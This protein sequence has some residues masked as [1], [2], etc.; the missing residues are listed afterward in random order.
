[1]KR[2]K[3]C[4]F[5]AAIFLGSNVASAKIG[6]NQTDY[7][8]RHEVAVSYG[9]FSNSSVI[10]TFDDILT[11]MVTGG[12]GYFDN[13]KF[14]GPISAEYFYRVN[15]WL[16]VGGIG[17]YATQGKDIMSEFSKTTPKEGT[18]RLNYYTLMPALKAD[19]LR[20]PHFGMYSKLGLGAT[21]FTDSHSYNDGTKNSDSAVGFTWQA[22]LLGLEAG[23][24]S[25][26]G[27]LEFS[28]IGEQGSIVI[29]LRHKF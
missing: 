1:M 13:E 23:S 14:I 22:S 19:W 24:N 9:F 15:N 20:R 25:L 26:R 4:F 10:S 21:I 28:L 11:I 5:I 12:H 17:A 3:V 8:N 27:F 18:A 7:E 29:G 6:D 2:L 16:G